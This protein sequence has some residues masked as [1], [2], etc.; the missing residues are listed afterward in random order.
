MPVV[1]K[2]IIINVPVEQVFDYVAD[3][4]NALTY[5]HSFTR[6]RPVTEKTRGLGAKVKAVGHFWGL[7]VTTDMEIVEF[8]KNKRLVSE[9]SSGIDSVATWLFDPTPE[10]TKVTFIAD[11]EPPP[12]AVGRIF[13]HLVRREV[14]RNAAYTLLNL[15]RVLEEGCSS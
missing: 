2:S 10:G 13:K 8:V 9:T 4:R 7:H 15:K 5:M 1:K 14:E 12:L 3:H 11:Y 6:F